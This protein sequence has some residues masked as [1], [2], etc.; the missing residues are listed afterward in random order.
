MRTTVCFAVLLLL[1]ACGGGEKETSSDRRASALARCQHA[2]VP[3]DIRDNI[4]Q[5]V[6]AEAQGFAAQDGRNYVDADKVTAAADRLQVRLD[7]IR[8]EGGSCVAKIR[9]SVP[10]TIL[11]TAEINAPLL[12]MDSPGET[13]WKKLSTGSIDFDGQAVLAQLRYT[14]EE[15]PF[16]VRYKDGLPAQ[17]GSVLSAAL[18]PYGVKDIVVK[19]GRPLSREDALRDNRS[20]EAAPPQPA[21][22][23]T[24]AERRR[25]ET[26]PETVVQTPDV[27]PPVPQAD[28]PAPADTEAEAQPDPQLEA[29]R[30]AH[31]QAD[32]DIKAAWRNIDPSIQ[33][34]LVEEQ[35]GWEKQKNRRCRQQAGSS[36]AD[37]ESAYLQCDTRETQKRIKYLNGYSIP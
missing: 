1:A 31:Q 28:A 29:V 36:D 30:A 16:S 5:T 35:R 3:H 27:P 24:L 18:L 25:K 17:I 10:Q 19:D 12:G 9:V 7:G 14:V 11:D 15:Q 21:E 4:R 20:P 2:A 6:R 23:D 32:R 26:P 8:A 13:I 22:T 33:Q 37:G 34:D